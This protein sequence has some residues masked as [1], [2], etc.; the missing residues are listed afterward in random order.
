MPKHR[1]AN[2]ALSLTLLAGAALMSAG[3]SACAPRVDTRGSLPDPDR[4]L[5][6]QPGIHTRDQVAEILGSPSSIGTFSDK[7]WYYMSRRTEQ[8][9]F[10]DPEVI[11]QQVLVVTFDD[12]GVVSD[13]KLY[14]YE[15]GRVIE[16]VDRTTPTSGRELTILQQIFGNLGRFNKEDEGVPRRT[17]Y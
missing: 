8:T 16:P 10:F 14:G 15:D 5:A 4:V 13:M 12:A 6:V 17:P 3:L 7:T 2:F 1:R 11:D 9:A